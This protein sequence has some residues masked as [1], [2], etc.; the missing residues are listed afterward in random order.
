M[1][2][3]LAQYLHPPIPRNNKTSHKETKTI[4][5]FKRRR[6][7]AS[8]D[9]SDPPT[10][11][12]VFIHPELRRPWI[13]QYT[14]LHLGGGVEEYVSTLYISTYSQDFLLFSGMF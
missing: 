4:Y 3:H 14:M 7:E 2:V 1:L 13:Q 10:Y 5:T 8:H 9:V 11:P 12:Q 6:V